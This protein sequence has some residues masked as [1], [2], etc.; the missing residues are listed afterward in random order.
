MPARW[1]TGTSM[2]QVPGLLTPWVIQRALATLSY[3]HRQVVVHACYRRA[4]AKAIAAS[5]S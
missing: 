3:E 2:T 5:A 4:S 1:S